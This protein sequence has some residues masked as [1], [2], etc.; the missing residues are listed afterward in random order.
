MATGDQPPPR[1][2]DNPASSASPFDDPSVELSSR[3]TGMSFQR[4]RLSADRTLMSVIRTSLSLISFGFTIYQFFERL[5]QTNNI[6]P[7]NGQARRFGLSL[8]VLGLVMLL[9]G[10]GY[11][12]AFMSGL[13][14]LRKQ[15]A[16]EGLIHAESAFPRSYTLIV[17]FLLLAVGMLAVMSLA[18]HVGPFG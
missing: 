14:G 8:V 6:A 13:R 18:F 15:M 4:T 16:G 17:A 5:A 10:I 1:P 12:I 2:P 11:D 3:R 7:G 9:V